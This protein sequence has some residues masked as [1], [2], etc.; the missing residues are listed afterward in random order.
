[1]LQLK[2]SFIG[3][4]CISQ[5]LAHWHRHCA[6]VF[7]GGYG[8][9]DM[10]WIDHDSSTIIRSFLLAHMSLPLVPSSL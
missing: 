9:N 4:R 7:F 2:F 6:G 1:M 5:S 10:T 3:G 8:M